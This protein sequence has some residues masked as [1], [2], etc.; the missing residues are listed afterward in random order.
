MEN[1]AFRLKMEAQLTECFAHHLRSLFPKDNS[2]DRKAMEEKQVQNVQIQS[3]NE[4]F[5]K[6]KLEKENLIA[7][8]KRHVDN[9]RIL[10]KIAQKQRKKWLNQISFMGLKDQIDKLKTREFS[11]KVFR[12]E[13]KM[14]ILKSVFAEFKRPF[15]ARRNERVLTAMRSALLQESSNRA[16]SFAEMT[17]QLEQILA[18]RIHEL[19]AKTSK[20]NLI[21][22]R[23]KSIT[24]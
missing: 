7:V 13:R 6:L 14:A 20:L 5:E 17:Q 9:K 22:E 10:T 24:N 18:G 11:A 21:K 12:F 19:A 1:E 4:R 2:L 23:Y 3:L 8:S 15:V 16:Q